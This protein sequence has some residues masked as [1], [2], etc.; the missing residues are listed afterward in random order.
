MACTLVALDT[1]TCVNANGG[2]EYA[3][4]TDITN[5]TS[6]TVT[7]GQISAFTMSGTDLWTKL[8]PNKN[9][10]ARYDQTGNRPNEFSTKIDYACEGF[11]YFAGNSNAL[12][13]VAD[14]LAACCRL[15]IIWV[16]NTGALVVQGL[17]IDAG[18][19]GGFTGSKEGDCRCTPNMLSDTSA[20][21]AR[22]EL[23][24]NSR[25]RVTSPYTT[26]T[27]TAIEAL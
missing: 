26:L 24:F 13:L 14:P 22:L 6:I 9:Q 20:N 3:Y 11:M 25:N 19:T 5:I 15:V 12:K 27:P 2:A 8:V 1:S 7:T 10:T 23:T 18:A 16:L 4:V 21:E 17:E